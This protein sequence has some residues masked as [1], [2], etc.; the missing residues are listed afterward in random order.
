MKDD[1]SIVFLKIILL[2]NILFL[3]EDKDNT[4][5]YCTASSLG[6]DLLDFSLYEFLTPSDERK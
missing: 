5:L 3:G 4:V 1:S 2:V 6:E